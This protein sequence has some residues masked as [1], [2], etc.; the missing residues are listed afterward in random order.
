MKRATAVNNLAGLPTVAKN[1]RVQSLIFHFCKKKSNIH[2]VKCS[3][4]TEIVASRPINLQQR[5]I[6]DTVVSS[7]TTNLN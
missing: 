3:S 2:K 1:D 5:N 4:F 6:T 7:T